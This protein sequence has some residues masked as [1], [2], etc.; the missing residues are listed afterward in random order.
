VLEAVPFASLK[1]A[2][3]RVAAADTPIPYS[4]PL[5]R[6][7]LPQVDDLVEGIRRALG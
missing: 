2:P 1:A 7:V 6:E 5:E 4:A 3:V